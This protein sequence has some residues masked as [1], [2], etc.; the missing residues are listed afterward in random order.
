MSDDTDLIWEAFT[1][2]LSE[3][4]LWVDP[5]RREH[6]GGLSSS[7]SPDARDKARRY[8]WAGKK[9]EN[10]NDIMSRVDE[11]SLEVY[12]SLKQEQD[13]LDYETG[14]PVNPIKW[15]VLKDDLKHLAIKRGVKDT[16]ARWF[17]RVIVKALKDNKIIR[18]DKKRNAVVVDAPPKDKAEDLKA[19]DNTVEPIVRK[20]FF[21]K[22]F[23]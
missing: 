7:L 16:R 23:S 15:S 1:K 10:E 17:M 3:S 22:W 14:D 6:A 20:G 19:I 5:D 18:V 11:I 12:D 9:D 21:K 8:G 13:R 4:P 2:K